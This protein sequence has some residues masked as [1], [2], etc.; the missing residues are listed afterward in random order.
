MKLKPGT[1]IYP[2][3][4]SLPI[5]WFHARNDR[6]KKVVKVKV[7]NNLNGV[8]YKAVTDKFYDHVNAR[9]LVFFVDKIP[10]IGEVLCVKRVNPFTGKIVKDPKAGI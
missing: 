2:D 9:A 5:A 10:E 4:S 6:K 8:T 7:V 3:D 1:I